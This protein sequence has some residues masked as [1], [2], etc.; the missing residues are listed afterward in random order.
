M[1][2]TRNA[3]SNEA[4]ATIIEVAASH[5][6]QRSG[7]GRSRSDAQPRPRGSTP[8]ERR[9][10]STRPG[11]GT[12]AMPAIRRKL[13]ARPPPPTPRGEEAALALVPGG[14]VPRDH[15]Q[16]VLWR[17]RHEIRG[18]QLPENA[19]LHPEAREPDPPVPHEPF[20][21]G[22][23]VDHAPKYIPAAL[24]HDR[25]PRGLVDLHHLPWQ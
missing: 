3:T 16:G 25:E 13:P 4:K 21:L 9:P 8:A 7:S 24:D 18:A 5:P 17:V 1:P 14:R 19:G 23:R 11:T 20:D 6:V 10:M 12:L 2:Y 22:V 15:R